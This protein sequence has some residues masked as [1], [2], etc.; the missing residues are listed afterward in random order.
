MV[1]KQHFTS[2]QYF[3]IIYLYSIKVLHFPFLILSW[4]DTFFNAFKK[5]KN[6]NLRNSARV[7]KKKKK[8][9]HYDC[10]LLCKTQMALYPLP[11]CSIFLTF[12]CYPFPLY[13]IS[14][15]RLLLSPCPFN[16]YLLTLFILSSSP[17]LLVSP[18]PSLLSLPFT[19]FLHSLPSY[20]CFLALRPLP[21]LFIRTC[22]STP[23]LTISPPLVLSPHS[24]YTITLSLLLSPRSH[25]TAFSSYSSLL[26]ALSRGS[27]ARVLACTMAIKRTNKM[28]INH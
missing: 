16:S 17:L 19:L 7:D 22:Y 28:N 23:L 15:P 12:Y 14:S 18:H 8:D 3:S 24:L 11:P 27:I 5:C 1:I 4:Q 26:C 6:V 21:R 9:V 25:S 20:S 10:L 13:G 2:M